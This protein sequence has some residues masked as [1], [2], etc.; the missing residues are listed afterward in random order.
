MDATISHSVAAS[1][2]G[3]EDYILWTITPE[4][5]G[6]QLLDTTKRYARFLKDS[7]FAKSHSE[8][9]E[10]F[11]RAAGLPNWHALQTLAQGIVDDFNPEVHWPRPRG[12]ELRIRPLATT[13]PFLTTAAK[14]C[15]PTPQERAGL[16]HAAAQLSLVCGCPK[17]KLLD[18]L[19]RMNGSDSWEQLLRRTPQEAT[20]PLYAFTVDDEGN[21]RFDWSDA[22][23]VLVEQ[24]DD[25]FQ[26]YDSRTKQEQKAF[27]SQLAEVL[28]RRPDFLEG[29]L[30]KAEI[31]RY[32]HDNG[33]MG[34][35]YADAI[36]Q[37]DAL[38]PAGFK[39]EVPWLYVSNRFYHRL[40]YGNM[41]WHAHRDHHAKAISLARRQLRLNKNDNLGVRLWLPVL[42][43]ASSQTEA[44]DKACLKISR[45]E[46]TDSGIELVKALCHYVNGR[47]QQAA[48]SLYIALFMF[49]SFRHVIKVDFEA[50]EESMN[51]KEK[52]RTVIPDPEQM[53]DQYVSVTACHPGLAE[54]FSG[55]LDMPGVVA[56]ENKLEAQFHANWRNPS[57]SIETWQRSLKLKAI[58][59]SLAAATQSANL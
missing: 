3:C 49:P 35:I 38:I 58:E 36:A 12:G 15:P 53:I 33:K 32:T 26:H 51:A 52:R 46:M 11:S 6:Q 29:L 42:L 44:A 55:W 24:Q 34:K 20:G 59:L 18:M 5:F 10:T 48:E 19:G 41:V 25:L 27:Q 37:A 31:L 17:E 1:S 30:A 8:G 43:S 47:L 2:F 14:D 22:C 28:A 13:I 45:G 16:E 23:E 9:M 54:V 57:A 4:V 40:L 39:G 7:G 56:A 21:G 50:L